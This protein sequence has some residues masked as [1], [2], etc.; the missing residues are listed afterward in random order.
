M[1][2]R[3]IHVLLTILLCA[4][5]GIYLSVSLIN[6]NLI[7]FGSFI[8]SGRAASLGLN[9]YGVYD[10]SWRVAGL[11]LPNLNPPISIPAF[12]SIAWFDPHQSF[13]A[14]YAVNV[15]LYLGI[16]VLLRRAYPEYTTV[17][18]LAWA[19]AIYGFW[20]VLISGQ[21][22]V[23][24]ALLAT[25]AWLSLRDGRRGRAAAAIGLLV[26]LKPNFC[27]LPVLLF[28]GG[29]RRE[30]LMS[31]AVTSV[32][33]LVPVLL[34]GP[35]IYLEWLRASAEIARL[36]ETRGTVVEL[37]S[38]VG[39]PWL[40]VPLASALSLA[41]IFWVWR[42][43]PAVLDLVGFGLV[44]SLLLLPETNPGYLLVLL[45]Y[46]LSRPWSVWLTLAAAVLVPPWPFNWYVLG[47]RI[48]VAALLLLLPEVLNVFPASVRS[49]AL[50]VPR[51]AVK[52]FGRTNGG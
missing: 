48:H 44:A 43:P 23:L 19:M 3:H 14:W 24:I 1:A 31:A 18:R 49:A 27:L 16:L 38:A 39:I 6:R 36:T 51:E 12:Q 26:A 47:S 10:L 34:Y 17:L 9:P 13:A 7:D 33:S 30:A 8:A 35:T 2:R 32:L 29:R 20:V 5:A 4:V 45:P 25:L 37:A 41:A 42:R 40:G 46:F 52:V 50:N 21:V 11:A 28:V 22:Y 15:A